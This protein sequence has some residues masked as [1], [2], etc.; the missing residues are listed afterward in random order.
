M[1]GV[2]E[3]CSAMA[4]ENRGSW[5]AKV[6]G[7]IA[8]RRAER[9]GFS[10]TPRLNTVRFRSVSPVSSPAS[11]SPC[12]LTIPPGLSPAA[13]LDSP[14]LLSSS[15][16][17]ASPS[18]GRLRWLPDDI[19]PGIPCLPSDEIQDT[20]H[21]HIESDG[22][23]GATKVK[24]FTNE[25]HNGTKGSDTVALESKHASLPTHICAPF[26]GVNVEPQL[27]SNGDQPDH[28]PTLGKQA[29]DGYNWR[30][31]GQK[32]VK[33]SVHPRSYYKCT[34]P[35]CQV[36][37]KVERSHDGQITEI[38]Y[39]GAHNH[40]KPQPSRRCAF[41]MPCSVNEMSD[42]TMGSRSCTNIDEELTLSSRQGSEDKNAAEWSSDGPSSSSIVTELSETLSTVKEKQPDLLKLTDDQEIPS[43]LNKLIDEEDGATQGTMSLEDDGGEDETESKRMKIGS[44]LIE[45]SSTSRAAHEQK[46]VVQTNSDVDI[47]DDGYRWRKYGQ[48]VVKGNPNPRSYYKCTN[49]GCS[50][51]K[52]VERASHD[53]KSVITTYEGK[54]NHEVPVTRNNSQINSC[55]NMQPASNAQNSGTLAGPANLSIADLRAFQQTEKRSEFG[56]DFKSGY[57]DSIIINQLA[58]TSFC[59]DMKAP[60]LQQMHWASFGLEINPMEAFHASS[61]P[62]IVQDYP[63]S[64]PT[65]LYRPNISLP[66]NELNQGSFILSE[67]QP[68][69]RHRH[70]REGTLR[71]RHPKQEVNN[72]N[73]NSPISAPS[74]SLA[75]TDEQYF[76]GLPL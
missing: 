71:Y 26:D 44:L 14:V 24:S 53:L 43:T 38:I 9:C 28:G 41:G 61:I 47:L 56:C 15:Q 10:V 2:A 16:A 23:A 60:T 66:S 74:D 21:L 13:L 6:A 54:H 65:E 46:V 64:T 42:A 20:V 39:R 75:F 48:K 76:G 19:A 62:N 70:P 73:Y 68:F 36:K 59:Y 69:L 1:G 22:Q 7:S 5:K 67:L 33:G 72:E 12:F 34:H 27:P 30:K 45:T 29:E 40:P 57:T 17:L 11:R 35:S 31:Y 4:S 37:K 8:E 25:E 49:P 58:G 3:Q 52:H 63:V 32:H 18:I 51:R 50:V 55:F